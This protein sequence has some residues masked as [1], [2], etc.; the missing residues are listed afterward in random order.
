MMNAPIRIL[1]V[2]ALCIAGLIGLVVR[3]SMARDAGVEV[4]LPMEAVDP[5]ALLQGHYV[6]ID[7]RE[8]LDPGEQ[9]PPTNASPDANGWVALGADGPIH[10]VVGGAGLREEALTRGQLLVRGGF[11]CQA[12]TDAAPDTPAQPGW[13]QLNIGIE[14]FY[15]DQARAQRIEQVLREQNV[16]E[17][18][19]AFAIVS[20]GQ[21]S[22]ARLRGLM[23]DD[24]RLELGWN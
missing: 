11:F 12:P 17:A 19:R 8:R 24:E 21:D 2:A 6:V 4:L 20:I 22:R 15:I 18:S 14:R 9:C 16:N 1:I 3:E 10:H 5:R 13:V 23:V 7:L